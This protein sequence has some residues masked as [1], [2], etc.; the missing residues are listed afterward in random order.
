MGLS[1]RTPP[2]I[3]EAI[4][5][6]CRELDS[7]QVP[8]YVPVRAARDSKRGECFFNVPAKVQSH[9]G[10]IQFGWVIW[11][12]P[13]VLVEAEYHSIWISP[14]DEQ[15]N[16]TPQPKNIRRILFLPASTWAYDY[17][18]RH[19]RIDNIRRPLSDDPLVAEFI[20]IS[21][22]IFNYGET[23]FGQYMHSDD[24][25]YAI[26]ETLQNRKTLIELQL[27]SQSQP[28]PN[29]SPPERNDPCPCGSGK[30][31]KNCHGKQ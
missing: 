10:R 21:E 5:A 29:Y 31:F 26:L 1:T 17:S 3:T 23:Y 8:V 28:H 12:W 2:K 24:P 27:K 19:Y 20:T 25:A 7:S 6:L 9:G 4:Q 22:R 13:H 11:E 16:I 14:K 30:K 15:I 18:R